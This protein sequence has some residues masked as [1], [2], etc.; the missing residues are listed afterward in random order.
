MTCKYLKLH[1]FDTEKKHDCDIVCNEHNLAWIGYTV[2]L[3]WAHQQQNAYL[4]LFAYARLQIIPFYQNRKCKQN[5][6]NVERKLM[7][8]TPYLT[9]HL[10]SFLETWF[11]QQHQSLYNSIKQI[12]ERQGKQ[13]KHNLFIGIEVCRIFASCKK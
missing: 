2:F 10:P 3:S 9:E 6:F 7:C 8:S 13:Y 5:N 4:V 11:P 1:I 12:S